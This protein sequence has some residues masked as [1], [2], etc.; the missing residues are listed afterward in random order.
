MTMVYVITYPMFAAL[1]R[2]ERRYSIIDN[3][4]KQFDIQATFPLEEYEDYDQFLEGTGSMILDRIN[5]FA[6][7]CLSP[8]THEV[9]L[10][11]YCKLTGYKKNRFQSYR[12]K[13]PGHLPH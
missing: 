8:R 4:A 13:R 3:L 7:A 1:R 6:Y 5:K 11:K 10:D 9:I 12:Q 2:M